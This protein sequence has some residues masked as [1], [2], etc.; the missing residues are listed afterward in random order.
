MSRRAVLGGAAGLGATALLAACGAGGRPAAAGSPFTFWDM[1]WGGTDYARNVGGL[2]SGW[3]P[4]DRAS[5]T[6]QNIPWANWYQT[7]AAAIAARKAPA[8]SSGA[9]FQPFEF[10]QQGAI[11]PADGVVAKL[12][13]SGVYDDFL[14]GT[15]ESLK[16][17]GA[18]V[19]VPYHIS[20]NG[21]WYRPDL[22]ERAGSSVPTTWDEFRATCRAL[23]RIGVYGYSIPGSP[24]ETG[25]QAVLPW[26]VNNG[27]GWFNAEGEPDCVTD[28]NIEAVEFLQSLVKDGYINPANVSYTGVQ[29]AQD[30][31]SGQLAMAMSG[32]NSD[33]QSWPDVKSAVMNP[34]TGPHG[35]KG[36]LQWVDPLMIYKGSSN[37]S[38]VED[39]VVWFL[40]AIKPAFGDGTYNRLPA[41]K[42]F[43]QLAAIKNSASSQVLLNEWLPIAKTVA[44]K[45]PE[46][47]PA[48]NS[49]EGAPVTAMFTGQIVEAEMSPRAILQQLQ[50]NYER[51]HYGK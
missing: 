45:S 43:Q 4:T 20:I 40:D 38:D 49:I 6:Y 31:S 13:K 34:L 36:A 5:A 11:E 19:A 12:R 21:L 47:F 46:L 51:L 16:Y 25:Y 39:F 1:Q 32:L 3:H 10:F 27:G 29:S 30:F 24:K 44:T 41:R 7:F 23:K 9:S 42:S 22:L 37:L 14:P 26:L 2:V 28:R 18:Y 17:R 15:V 35:E 8:V 33:L 50:D 48:L